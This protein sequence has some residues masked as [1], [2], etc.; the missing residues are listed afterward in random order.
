MDEVMRQYLGR[1]VLSHRFCQGKRPPPRSAAAAVEFAI[2]LPFLVLLL[3]ITAD[4]GR[5][6]YYT[7]TIDNCVHNGAIFLSHT[8]DNQNQQWVSS[9]Q[10]W[11][12]PKGEISA[13]V[14]ATLA[15]GASLSPPLTSDNVN[16]T[17][18]TDADGNSVAI[19]T[20]TY[21]FQ[22]ITQCPGVPTNLTIVRSCQ[23]RVA[24]A[25]P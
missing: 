5:V 9:N 22:T 10:Y 13:A 23:T 8:F 19:V 15:D 16:V 3:A 25:T 18:G 1:S 21:N 17:S 11:Q 24:P 6:I 14:D 20:V 7:V 2:V 12:G 4:F